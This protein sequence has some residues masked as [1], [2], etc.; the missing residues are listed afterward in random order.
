MFEKVDL[1]LANILLKRC[2]FNKLK[3]ELVEIGDS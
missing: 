3:P 1:W 2:A